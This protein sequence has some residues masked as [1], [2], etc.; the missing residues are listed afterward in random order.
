MNFEA[1]QY[2]NPETNRIE[3]L[4]PREALTPDQSKFRR[5]LDG[6][7]QIIE[8]K[9]FIKNVCYYIIDKKNK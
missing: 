7:L 2:W 1:G 9:I 5:C 6:N 3:Y 4:D 8:M